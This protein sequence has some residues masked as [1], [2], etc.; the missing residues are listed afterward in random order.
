MLITVGNFVRQSLSILSGEERKGFLNTLGFENYRILIENGEDFNL[1]VII[2][3]HENE[4]LINDMRDVFSEVG[5]NHTEVIKTWD[6][7]EDKVIGIGTIIQTLIS[8]GKYDGVYYGE[9]DPKAKR[10]RLFENV[11]MGLVR[12]VQK[13]PILLCIEDLQWSD[14]SSLALIHNISKNSRTYGLV[15]IGTFRADEIISKGDARHPMIEI[16]QL[17]DREEFFFRMELPRLPKECI[18]EIIT[19]MFGGAQIDDEVRDLIYRET[20]GNPLFIIELVKYLVEESMIMNAEG[21]WKLAMKGDELNIPPKIYQVI[22]RRMSR[23]D[24]RFRDLLDYASV[25]GET[26]SSSVLVE[27]LKAQRFELLNQLR[28]LEQK[29]KLI[30]SVDG[31]YRFAHAKIKE[32]IYSEIPPELRMS[33][34]SIIANS[35]ET[36]NKGNLDKVLENLA[37]HYYQCKN[38]AKALFYLLLAAKKARNN[39]SNK[40]SIRFYQEALDL[41]EMP[42]KRIEL[43]TSLGEIYDSIGEYDKSLGVFN[44]SLSLTNDPK[45]LADI[46]AKIGIIY[47]KKGDYDNSIKQST[48]TLELVKNSNSKEEASGLETLGLIAH[49]KGQYDNALKYHRKSLEIREKLNDLS[50]KATSLKN[51]GLVLL[52]QR[53]YDNALKNYTESLAIFEGLNDIQGMQTCL[54]D[55]AALNFQK[56]EYERAFEYYNRSYNIIG[57]TGDQSSIAIL[58]L[59]IGQSLMLIDESEKALD[60]LNK[61]LK[62]SKDNDLHIVTACNYWVM[63]EIYIKKRELRSALEYCNSAFKIATELGNKEIIAALRRVFG[64]I[65]KEQRRWE[66]AIDNFGVSIKIYK[67]I[68]NEKE[69]GDTYFEYGLMWKAKG[70]VSRAKDTLKEAINIFKKLKLGKHSDKVKSALRDL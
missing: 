69:L 11:S 49:R 41:E 59:N 52:D 14:P 26:F 2:T 63:A 17:L 37:F 67:E 66:A 31:N 1:V 12:E 46:R 62:I 40:E 42:L 22:L 9:S 44:S 6:G 56:G 35:I 23:L 54:N 48:L 13:K 61:S 19:S 70:E 36:L 4:F 33:Y 39:Y 16:M 58:L 5:K 34:H 3:G 29:F 68:D 21:T 38:K 10:N 15:I 24:K 64:I 53:D 28:D 51:I 18:G 30:I 60:N 47:L 57:A 65:Y 27:A 7:D 45:M 8:S 20:E 43:L 32:V 50:G 25:I 55:I